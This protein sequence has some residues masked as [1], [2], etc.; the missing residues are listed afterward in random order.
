MKQY[1]DLL[2]R[3]AEE[4]K[5]LRISSEKLSILFQSAG[6]DPFIAHA[7]VG[8]CRERQRETLEEYDVY[9]PTCVNFP[10]YEALIEYI[11]CIEEYSVL[12]IFQRAVHTVVPIPYLLQNIQ[13][14]LREFSIWQWSN[15][16]KITAPSRH[17][18]IN[19]CL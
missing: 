9:D 15:V 3:I 1:L 2:K 14:F 8:S 11:E 17:Y 10:F 7:E 18:T 5:P 4:V 16:Q 12:M 13:R 19:R 6:I